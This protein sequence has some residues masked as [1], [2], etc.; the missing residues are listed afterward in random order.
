[1]EKHDVWRTPIWVIP[2]AVEFEKQLKSLT[3]II[4]AKKNL[5]NKDSNIS[6]RN[7]WR[8]DD[9]HKLKELSILKDYIMWTTIKCFNDTGYNYKNKQLGFTSWLNVHDKMGYNNVHHHGASLLSGVLYIN[10]PEGSGKIHLR[11]PR[12]V[13]SMN[14]LLPDCNRNFIFEPKAGSTIL[15][16][17]FLEHFVEPSIADEDDPRIA[18]AFNVNE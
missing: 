15:F 3:K 1:M 18:V 8:I 4:K 10:C 9:P 2:P 14:K 7:G 6:I 17:G 11:D 13:A 16:P 5:A 12:P